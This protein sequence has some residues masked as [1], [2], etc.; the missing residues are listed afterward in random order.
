ML[1]CFFLVFVFIDFHGIPYAGFLFCHL[2]VFMIP[3]L[4]MVAP[5]DYVIPL[6]M[7]VRSL[8]LLLWY[9][10]MTGPLLRRST[11]CRFSGDFRV[12]FCWCCEHY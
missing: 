8:S 10:V 12:S 3:A 9:W 11:R 5:A 7:F 1:V 4:A 2:H 6:G